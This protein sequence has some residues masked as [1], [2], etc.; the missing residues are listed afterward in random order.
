[1]GRERYNASEQQFY[2]GYLNS[3]A[4]KAKKAARIKKAGNCCEFTI[5]RFGAGGA[6]EDRCKRQRYLCVHH[7]TYERLG[8]EQDNDL[9]VFCWAHHM[10]EH[11]LWKRCFRCGTTPVLENDEVAERWLT[12][13]LKTMEIDLDSGPINWRRLPNKEIL[14]AQLPVTCPVCTSQ[15][16]PRVK[17]YYE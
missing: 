1:M 9:D 6:I 5:T 17:E 16:G 7:N 10:V 4:W 2:R 15:L 13:T 11:L 3:P 14:L 8:Y 12:I